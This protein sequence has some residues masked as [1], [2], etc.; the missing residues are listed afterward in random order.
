M[1]S[2]AIQG[3]LGFRARVEELGFKG[4]ALRN[5]DAASGAAGSGIR[6]HGH[7]AL[8]VMGFRRLLGFRI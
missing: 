8:R 5:R 7:T 3:R 4:K 2:G 1:V 6:I